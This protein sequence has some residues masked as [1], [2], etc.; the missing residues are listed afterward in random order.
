MAQATKSTISVNGKP[1]TKY[2][3]FSLSQGIYD[4]HFFR[5]ACPAEAID[6]KTGIVFNQSKTWMGKPFYIKI[7][8]DDTSKSK[9]SFIFNGVVTQI[10]TER[11]GGSVGQVI[12]SGYSPTIMLESGPHCKTWEKKAVKNIVQDVLKHFPQDAL[13][14]KVNPTYPETLSYY[15]QYKETAWQFLRRICS[16]YGE[17]LLYNGES[18]VIG[19]LSGSAK[20]LEFGKTIDRFTI[21]LEVAPPSKKVMAYDYLNNEVL[22]TSPTGIPGQAGLSSRGIDVHNASLELYG[23]EPKVWNNT[24]LTNKKQLDKQ[25]NIQSAMLSC[26]H[27]RFT[28]SS[29]YLGLTV[30][31]KV[32]ISGVNVT[33]KS[34]EDYGTHTIISINHFAGENGEYRNDFIAVPDSIK[35][36]PVAIVSDPDCETQSAIVTDN[37]DPLHLGRV[38][39][40]FHWMKP[41]EKTPWI[42]VTSPHG[43]GDKGMY[44]IPEIGEEA[45]ICFEGNSAVKPFVN[46]MVYHGK[47]KTSFANAG[48][49][50]KALRTRSGIEIK[51][52]DKDGSLTLTDPSGNVVFM[53]GKENISITCK[54]TFTVTAKDIVMTASNNIS[55]SATENLVQD[56]KVVGITAA[57]GLT[58][59]GKKVLVNGTADLNLV[60][61]KL[62]LSGDDT[63]LNSK[64]ASLNASGDLTVAGGLVKINS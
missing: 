27:E 55:V 17:W 62:N 51:M 41:S 11:F 30:G 21:S 56:G 47:A 18:L 46:G 8:H 44:F 29:G 39:A 16:S 9:D 35:L 36:P 45:I 60:T 28:G 19:P 15:V 33:D 63:T 34:K 31:S 20:Q 26:N 50:I 61:P 59:T 64:K 14:P 32:S 48:N 5:L 7:D 58:N 13:K 1:I 40:R 49:D 54:K 12:I 43:G 2:S 37:N 4:H 24:F 52:N 38:R 10:Q 57:E 22:S 25:V 6:G 23:T 3:S 53:D 42:R